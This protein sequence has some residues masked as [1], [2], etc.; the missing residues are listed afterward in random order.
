M[1]ERLQKIISRAGIASRREAERL[2]EAGE[3]MVDGK[4]VTELGTK[5][6]AAEH[7]IVVQGKKIGGTEKQVYFLL[8][9]PKGYLS[10]V[11]D[12][13]GRKTVIDLLS[14]VAE[15]IYPVGRLDYSTE[16]LLLLTNDGILMNAL[17]HPRGGIEKTY[18]AS[19]TGDI[20]PEKLK[21]LR[22]G[23]ML[24]DGIT[25]PARVR[26]LEQNPEKGRTKLEV[27][28]HEGR[29]RQVR[30]MF[31]AVNCDVK[32][33][34]RINFAGLNLNGVKRGC[35]RPLTG[36]ELVYLQSLTGIC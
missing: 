12:D 17:L 15:R 35:Y 18:I 33:L 5:L 26:V 8:N 36:E 11:K 1:E 7:E 30:R 31:A 2:I 32:A 3:V 20:T 10:T 6:V 16:G 23:V 13:R 22:N 34:K 19:V 24:E 27:I 28:I 4:I 9:K 25:A 21:L 14:E 29:N